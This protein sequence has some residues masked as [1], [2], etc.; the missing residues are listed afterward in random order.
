M[1]R[2]HLKK[3]AI[4]LPVLADEDR[5]HHRLHIVID[6][7][8]AGALEESERP[9]VG[10]EHHLLRLARISAHEHHAAVAEADMGDLHGRGHPVHHHDLVAPIEL[11]GLARCKNERHVSLRQRGAALLAPGDRIT[12]NRGVAAAVTEAP[13]LLE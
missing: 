6:A 1:M 4:V 13:Q 8:R 5:L 11:V 3:A 10:V 2:A 9:I 12:S 7:A